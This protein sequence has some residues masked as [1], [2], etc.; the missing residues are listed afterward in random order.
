LEVEDTA[1]TA[2]SQAWLRFLQQPIQQRLR[3]AG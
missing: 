1:H 2:E 3:L